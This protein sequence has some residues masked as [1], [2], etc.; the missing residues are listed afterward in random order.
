MT[1]TSIATIVQ[2]NNIHSL[3]YKCLQ[4]CQQS[5]K[6]KFLS[7]VDDLEGCFF[8]G[9]KLALDVDNNSIGRGI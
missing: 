4:T 2:H 8:E 3:K 5:R 6:N 1:T 9:K 7:L